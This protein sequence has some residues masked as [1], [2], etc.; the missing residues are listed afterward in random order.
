MTRGRFGKWRDGMAVETGISVRTAQN[1]MKLADQSSDVRAF[2]VPGGSLM[3][4][5]RATGV[6]PDPVPSTEDGDDDADTPPPPATPTL[7]EK[8]FTALAAGRK[9][10]RHLAESGEFLDEEDRDRLEREKSA[11]LTLFDKLLN[12]IVP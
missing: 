4:A 5:Y 7:T 9:K 8:A 11:Y 12:P 6:L 3:S 10:L 1:W 2:L